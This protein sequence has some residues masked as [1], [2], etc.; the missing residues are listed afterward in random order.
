MPSPTPLESTAT[1]P[2][3][4]PPRAA[5]TEEYAAPRQPGVTFIDEDGSANA[6]AGGAGKAGEEEGSRVGVRGEED[7]RFYY[8]DE[9]SEDEV[10]DESE[11][12]EESM[13]R[14]GEVNDEDW[15]GAERGTSFYLP[16][17]P[18]E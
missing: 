5:P 11:E 6:S 7:R 13:M 9:D 10:W 4:I 1:A 17:C 16:P 15:E 14:M 12:E 18:I 8:G 2:S 3:S